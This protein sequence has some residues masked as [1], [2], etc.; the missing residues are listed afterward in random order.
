MFPAKSSYVA[1]GFLTALLSF[2]GGHGSPTCLTKLSLLVSQPE[3]A[4][5]LCCEVITLYSNPTTSVPTSVFV[6]L[7]ATLRF[8]YV[9]VEDRQRSNY[10]SFTPGLF[11]Y[12]FIYLS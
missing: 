11:I 9:E 12:L 3:C 6:L 1:L 4:S 2:P 5:A 10:P 8:V 7:Y